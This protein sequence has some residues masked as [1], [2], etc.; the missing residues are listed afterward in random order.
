MEEMMAPPHCRSLCSSFLT[1]II[2][3]FAKGHC[4]KY[5]NIQCSSRIDEQKALFLTMLVFS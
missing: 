4:E 2:K 1:G 3:K 5:I